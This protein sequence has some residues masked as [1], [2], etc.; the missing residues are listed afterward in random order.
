VIAGQSFELI[1]RKV[2]YSEQEDLYRITIFRKLDAAVDLLHY[3]E[4]Q[5]LA[6]N[7]VVRF[8][9]IDKFRFKLFVTK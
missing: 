7:K 6:E 2:E 3:P 8:E 5:E 1:I 4:I 9:A